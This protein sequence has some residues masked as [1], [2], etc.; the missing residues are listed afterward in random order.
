M[1]EMCVRERE[2]EREGYSQLPGSK[3]A[4][5]TINPGPTWDRKLFHAGSLNAEKEREPQDSEQG[6]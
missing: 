4:K 5:D 3:Y 1:L 2:R 6:S